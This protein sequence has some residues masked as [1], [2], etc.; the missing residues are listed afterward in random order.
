MLAKQPMVG[1]ARTSQ[2]Q[3]FR[4]QSRNEVVRI[5]GNAWVNVGDSPLLVECMQQFTRVWL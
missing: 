4:V 1:Q 5:S 3:T 2:M